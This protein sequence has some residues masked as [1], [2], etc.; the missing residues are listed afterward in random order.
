MWVQYFNPKMRSPGPGSKRVQQKLK[1]ESLH[2]SDVTRP[3]DRRRCVKCACRIGWASG[4]PGRAVTL[5]Q[6]PSHWHASDSDL[7]AA[8]DHC[9]ASLRAA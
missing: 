5:C 6:T 7:T 9:V 8:T 3:H 4:A 2:D 1:K